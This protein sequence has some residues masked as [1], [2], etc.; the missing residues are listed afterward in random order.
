MPTEVNDWWSDD[1]A[2]RFWLVNER[3]DE[4]DDYE[5]GDEGWIVHT[6][7][8]ADGSPSIFA[9]LIELVNV[10]DILFHYW[11]QRK[12]IV[13]WSEIVSDARPASL[14]RDDT[15]HDG[16]DPWIDAVT[17]DCCWMQWFR[18]PI[19]LASLRGVESDIRA[20]RDALVS[21]YGDSIYF[22]WQFY[23]K[24]Q[25]LRPAQMYLTKLPADAVS[26]L[27]QLGELTV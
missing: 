4:Q 27:R 7:Q 20:L 6:E 26:I 15:D 14:P 9:S 24:Q 22:P 17:I 1:P 10:G 18:A 23:G 3:D 16:D 19:S 12:A 8:N 25:R 5:E 11:P 2:E 21:K 13:G